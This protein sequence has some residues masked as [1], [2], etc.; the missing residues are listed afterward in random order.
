MR[1][2][3]DT[4][5]LLWAATEP[6]K[7]GPRAKAAIDDPSN[8]RLFSAVTIWELA[9]KLKID[10]IEVP[11]GLPRFLSYAKSELMLIPLNVI[12]EHALVVET[13]PL[14][15]RDPFDR[16]L[17]AQSLYE[18]LPIISIDAKLDAYGVTRIW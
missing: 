16:M 3:L 18:S 7:L 12:P 9:I 17:V 13:L 4:H 5:V 11:G 8:E 15:H 14:H 2:L 6:T 1:F 10:K